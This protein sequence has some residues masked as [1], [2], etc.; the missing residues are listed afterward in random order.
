MIVSRE[1]ATK[2]AQRPIYGRAPLPVEVD[3]A[4]THI[5]AVLPLLIAQALREYA[6]VWD[7]DDEEHKAFL[8]QLAQ[9]RYSPG[10][11]SMPAIWLRYQAE[12]LEQR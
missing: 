7:R 12:Q 3:E 8:T 9:E 1:I 11:P 4:Q 2:A 6:D 10:G 5:E